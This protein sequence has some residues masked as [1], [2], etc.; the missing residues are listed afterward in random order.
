MRLI[1][2][3]QQKSYSSSL[4]PGTNELPF[5]VFQPIIATLAFNLDP[6]GTHCKTTGRHLS[7]LPFAGLRRLGLKERIAPGLR[8]KLRFNLQQ[9]IE[10][11]LIRPLA[12]RVLRVNGQ[13][14]RKSL[15]GGWG[16]HRTRL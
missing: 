13:I 1:P 14:S 9:E 10:E 8:T 7:F 5:F 12:I 4:Y 11:T 6:P 2:Y 3:F 16:F 15:D